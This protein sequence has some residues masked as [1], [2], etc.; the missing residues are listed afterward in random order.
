M[1]D[2]AGKDNLLYRVPKPAADP[3]SELRRLVNSFVWTSVG[4]GQYRCYID[5]EQL[6]RLTLL[7]K[8]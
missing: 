8:S 2:V 3:D 6:T 1:S 7:T 5:A 4:N